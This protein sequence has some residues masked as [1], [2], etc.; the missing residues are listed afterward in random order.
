MRDITQQKQAERKLESEHALLTA[1]INSAGDTIIFSLD[2][3]Y[4]YT[5]FNKA[6]C[7][8]MKRVWN[9][10]I[11]IGMNLLDCMQKPELREL[12]KQS[13][14]HALLGEAFS[15]I[16]H[17]PDLD[18]YYEFNW[19]PIYQNKNIVGATVF[20]KD[21]T[22]RK[23][24]EEA[25]KINEEKLK[26]LFESAPVGYHE[27]DEH[28]NIKAVNQTELKMLG[29]SY[30]EMEG[31][32]A[33]EF[34]SDIEESRKRVLGKLA[35]NLPPNKNSE[36]FFTRKD[37]TV[38]PALADDV[39]LRNEHRKITGIRTTIL[40]ITER[41][42]SE[43]KNRQL[44]Q[45]LIQA[46]KLES[47][48]TLASGIAHDFNNILGIILAYSSLLAK[49][50]MGSEKYSE[51]LNAITNAVQRGAALVRQILT[52]ARKTD[53][54]FEPMN[55]MD[56]VHELLSML[57]QTFPKTI[58]FKENIEKDIPYIFADRTQIYQAL[59][60]LYVNARDAMPKSG[61]IT[62][63]IEKRTGGQIRG[64]F[65]T[66]NQDSYLCVSVTDNGM[67]LDEATRSRIFDPFFTTKEKGK[68]TG[69]GL[70]V[71]F[72]VVQTHHGFIYVESEP[73]KGTTFLLYLP[74]LQTIEPIRVEEGETIIEEKLCGTE[75]L[76]VIEDEKA[77][78]ELVRLLLET[79]G[80]KVHTAQDGNEAIE[81][82][83]RYKEEI[84]IVLTDMGLPGMVGT[85]VFNALREINPNV[86]VIFASGVIEPDAKLE[87][88]KAGAKGFIQKPYNPNEILRKLREVLD[89]K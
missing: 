19:N 85:D 41:K 53:I 57:Q 45:Q 46:Q 86:R 65:P 61:C 69:L 33:W 48:G 79:K 30:E 5:A 49:I 89:E 9:A 55:L 76:L 20:I 84:D 16:Q 80:Y 22:E 64:Q 17:Q 12:A 21:I 1:M 44:Q 8:E 23:R 26:E 6:H 66:A 15:E 71:V 73:G 37:G 83:K 63:A 60:N 59:L 67:G 28:G 47:L 36:Q 75:T 39:I 24:I 32:Q 50:K 51:S 88:S 82:Y 4:C 18:I 40:D 72:G 13:I 10:D 31:W 25:L 11:K 56:L 38:F 29:Y 78:S 54:L 35:G 70:S 2:K 43:E 34:T 68:G 52:F 81:V 7:K 27:I 74:A 87:L 14:D 42:Q 77:L 3:N 62:L 58:I